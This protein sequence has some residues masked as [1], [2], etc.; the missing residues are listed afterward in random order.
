MTPILT[1]PRRQNPIVKLV[2]HP[3][4]MHLISLRPRSLVAV[5]PR[6]AGLRAFFAWAFSS[7]AR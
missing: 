2:N 5:H 7:L 6:S 3:D 4:G 1:I